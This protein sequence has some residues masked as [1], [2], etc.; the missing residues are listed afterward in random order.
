VNPVDMTT[1]GQQKATNEEF[2]QILAKM[3][4]SKNSN[5]MQN[6]NYSIMPEK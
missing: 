1:G 3:L 4:Y 2:F 5:S 6:H